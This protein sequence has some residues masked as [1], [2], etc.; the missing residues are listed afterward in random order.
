[1]EGRGRRLR[2]SFVGT[3]LT[4]HPPAEVR[5]AEMTRAAI[6]VGRY[7]AGRPRQRPYGV[8]PTDAAIATR[9]ISGWLGEASADRPASLESRGARGAGWPPGASLQTAQDRQAPQRL[10]R[11]S[12]GDW[13][14]VTTVPSSSICVCSYRMLHDR[15]EGRVIGCRHQNS[16]GFS[17]ISVFQKTT[18]GLKASVIGSMWRP[19]GN[20]PSALLIRKVGGFAIGGFF[21]PVWQ[22]RYSLHFRRRKSRPGNDNDVTWPDGDIR[23]R[24]PK[25][26]YAQSGA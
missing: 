24:L 12:S 17:S 25:P 19:A 5:L 22:Q 4:L 23:D 20:S 9:C 18:R 2:S 7:Q 6:R 3:T 15:P 11:E 8:W 13:S 26:D 16:V 1:M 10:A 21:L 14:C